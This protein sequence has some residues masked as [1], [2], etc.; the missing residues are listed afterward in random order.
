MNKYPVEV[1]R[2]VT[3]QAGRDAGRRFLVIRELDQDFILMADGNLR[4]MDRPKKK[5]R[6]HLKPSEKVDMALRTKRMGGEPVS[7]KEIR[8]TLSSEEG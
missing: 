5:R 6:R 3:S 1:G 7:D 4:T 8:E 2:I